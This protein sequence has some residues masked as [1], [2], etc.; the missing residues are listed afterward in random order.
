MASSG[1]SSLSFD[2]VSCH[3]PGVRSL[4]LPASLG[5]SLRQTYANPVP[6]CAGTLTGAASRPK[7]ERCHAPARTAN[8]RRGGVACAPA[9]QRP[10]GRV[11]PF[12]TMLAGK[13][14]GAGGWNPGPATPPPG[15]LDRIFGGVGHAPDDTAA[16]PRRTRVSS[17][18]NASAR[19]GSTLRASRST[20]EV[21]G[22][23]FPPNPWRPGTCL[24]PCLSDA[25][26]ARRAGGTQAGQEPPTP[27]LPRPLVCCPLW[28]D[29]HATIR[30]SARNA[31]AALCGA[32]RSTRRTLTTGHAQ[33]MQA[34]GL[35]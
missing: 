8:G 30:R 10:S 1:A 27:V 12:A 34:T 19:L 26:G 17:R 33:V 29:P 13:S 6:A 31:R 35:A 9:C 11:A 16:S 21:P 15:T 2:A 24:V 23:W 28:L 4:L 32:Y 25:Q 7:G 20:G 5:A 22:R 18:R 14:L 3:A